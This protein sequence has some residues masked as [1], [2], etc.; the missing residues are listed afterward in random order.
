MELSLCAV[1]LRRRAHLDVAH[2][3]AVLTAEHGQRGRDR[4]RLG[5]RVIWSMKAARMLSG[6]KRAMQ[7]QRMRLTTRALVDDFEHGQPA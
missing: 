3:A 6:S 7:R 5:H 1:G 2:G 4:S